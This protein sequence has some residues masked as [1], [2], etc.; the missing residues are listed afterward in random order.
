M[1]ANITTWLISDIARKSTSFQE[2]L[3]NWQPRSYRQFLQYA[4]PQI[5]PVLQR[6]GLRQSYAIRTKVDLVTIVSI[7]EDEAGAEAAWS[8]IS[9][10]LHE[11]MDGRLEFLEITSGPV[12]DLID[13]SQQFPSANN[14]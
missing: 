3:R 11:L 9:G 1:H 10:G 6:C 4:A 12:D 5:V 13:I 8:E 14:N 2:F 7:F